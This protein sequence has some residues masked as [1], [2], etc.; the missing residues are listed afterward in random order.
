MMLIMTSKVK[1]QQD[2]IKYFIDALQSALGNKRY[3]Q[4]LEVLLGRLGELSPDEDETLLLLSKDLTYL[5]GRNW[6]KN[7]RF[8]S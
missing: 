1:A 8:P 7:T 6:Q 5:E 3:L 2:G 4:D